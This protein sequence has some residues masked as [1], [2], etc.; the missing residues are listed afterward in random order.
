M[1]D[2]WVESAL[3]TS[4]YVWIPFRIGAQGAIVLRDPGRWNLGIFDSNPG[5][6]NSPAATPSPR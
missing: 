1:A 2:R 4:S 3:D 5:V 6:L